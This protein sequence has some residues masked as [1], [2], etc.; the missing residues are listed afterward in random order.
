MNGCQHGMAGLLLVVAALGGAAPLGRAADA[1]EE[2][3]RRSGLPTDTASL[4]A[5]LKG[6]ASTLRQRRIEELIRQL[7]S[8]KFTE[9]QS[10]A[11]ALV[12]IDRPALP[13]LE[14]AAKDRDAEVARRARESRKKIR[15]Q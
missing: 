1:E 11:A 9:R 4:R 2:Q 8:T 13:A 6:E 12:A 7:G 10:A 3:L 15:D 14:E 5:I